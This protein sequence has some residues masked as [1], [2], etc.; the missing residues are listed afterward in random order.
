VTRI[1]IHTGA[2]VIGN[3]GGNER[4]EYT[5]MGDAINTAARL[6]SVNKY[7]GTRVC[8]SES[9]VNQCKGT[10]FRPI[11]RL[12]LKGKSIGVNVF[13]P[14][15]ISA[16]RAADCSSYLEAYQKMENCEAGAFDAFAKLAAQFG[17]DYLVSFHLNRLQK[18][19]SGTTI[20]MKEK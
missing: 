3:F 9:T 17:D 6:E 7:L 12:F 1:G 16:N 19:E 18:G 20:V 5:A 2:T 11:G 15:D 8:I 10:V 14:I 4:I 13:E